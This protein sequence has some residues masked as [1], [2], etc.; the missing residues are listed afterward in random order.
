MELHCVTT[1]ESTIICNGTK[2]IPEEEPLDWHD[3]WFWIYLG[4][5]TGLVIFA[6]K[7]WVFCFILPNLWVLL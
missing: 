1:H 6:G 5:Y 3:E 2:Y 4:I 7:V